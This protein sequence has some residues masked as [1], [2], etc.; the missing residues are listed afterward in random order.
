MT[1]VQMITVSK[2]DGDLRLDR[3][4]RRHF[5][6]L[7]HGQLQKMLRK[8]QVRVEGARVAADHR[9][10]PGQVVRVPPMPLAPET[11][12][13]AAVSGRDADFVRSLVLYEDDEVLALNKP[14]G[15]A[16][17][18]GTKTLRHLDGM[19]PALARDGEQPRLVHRLDRD[20]GGLLLLGRSRKAAAT[21]AEAFRQH[22]VEKVY[23]A[24]TR[25]VPHP[26]SGRIDLALEKGKTVGAG[27]RVGPQ[28]S[29]KRALTDFQVVETAGQKAA[30]VA[31]RPITGRTHQIRVHLAAL[32][33]PIV[34]D[35]KYGGSDAVLEGISPQMHLFCRSMAFT[36]PG[37]RPLTLTAP[38]TGHM[39]KTW[40]WFGFA[41]PDDLE[42]PD[43]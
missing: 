15:L 4:F 16:V 32:G 7:R 19:L 17:Q 13:P 35:R 29:G 26:V 12:K 42:W 41:A 38:L 9:L 22:R 8:G 14:F 1:D 39:A 20:T 3:W 6:Q 31:L 21:L 37:R 34:G 11:A 10:T 36:L 5:P 27:E 2:A 24:L 40:A 33:T 28:R 18:G 43:D 25:R 30:F 23:W